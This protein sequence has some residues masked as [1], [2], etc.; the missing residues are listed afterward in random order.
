MPDDIEEPIERL[1]TG[2]Y[3]VRATFPGAELRASQD[4]SPPV[5]FGHLAL[6]NEWAKVDSVVEGRFIERIAPGAFA[7]TIAE[8]RSRIQPI[9]D[10][11]RD[12]QFGRR[13]LG[14][15]TELRED[16]RGVYYEVGLFDTPLIRSEL[17]PGLSGGAYGASFRFRPTKRPTTNYSPPRSA[18][19]PQQ[20]PEVTVHE[21]EMAEFGPTPFPVYAGATAGARSMTDE[22]VMAGFA[23]DPE[24]LRSLM[25][26][27]HVALPDAGA[28]PAHSDEGSREQDRADEQPPPQDAATVKTTGPAPAGP[29]DSRPRRFRTREEFIEWISRS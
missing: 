10:H 23:R 20:W 19:N 7:K 6:F 17:L 21:L 5:M 24:Y 13:P 16:E 18:Y 14:K 15:I 1:T 25:A 29:S 4:G 2:E 22:I 3:L 12:V 26:A 8:S 11:G 27:A 28:E 9:Y